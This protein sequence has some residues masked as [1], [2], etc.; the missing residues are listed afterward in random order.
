MLA[1]PLAASISP[2]EMIKSLE[3]KS[4]EIDV[5]RVVDFY[6]P[7][8]AEFVQRP[9]QYAM[10]LVTFLPGSLAHCGRLI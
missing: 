1:A 7:N 5:F 3:G 6:S 9:L 2:A 4:D 8:V 10:A